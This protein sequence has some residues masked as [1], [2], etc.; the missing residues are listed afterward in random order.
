MNIRKSTKKFLSI[1]MA[2]IFMSLIF[3]VSLFAPKKVYASTSP[4]IS[5]S[6]FSGAGFE[7]GRAHV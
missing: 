6:N 2:I 3:Q 1:T 7:I 5:Y 4:Q